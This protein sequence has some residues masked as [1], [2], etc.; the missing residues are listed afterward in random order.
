MDKNRRRKKSRHRKRKQSISFPAII[1]LFLLLMLIPLICMWL[2]AK[3]VEK[4]VPDH[5]T[6]YVVESVYNDIG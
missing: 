2:A 1:A 6:G 5:A 3:H 4:T